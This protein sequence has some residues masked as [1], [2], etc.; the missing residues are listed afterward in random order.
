MAE[1]P[2]IE[3]LR[4]DL[5]REVAG[6]RVK[7]VEM[8]SLK[9]FKHHQNRKQVVGRLEG[10]KITGVRRRGVLLVFR[11][12]SGDALV[13]DVSRAGHLVRAAA[14]DEVA[15]G[16]QLIITFTQGGQL[17]VIDPTNGDVQMLITEF[18]AI[19]DVFPDLAAGG[20][21]PVEPINW[22]RFA[23]TLRGSSLKLKALL[24]D[25]S[26][27]L[28]IGPMYSDEIL[29]DSGL[30]GDRVANKLTTQEERR[31]Y[32]SIVEIMH[33]AIKHRGTSIGDDGFR[34]LSGAPGNYLEYI[35]AYERAGQACKRCRGTIGKRKIVGQQS[36]ACPDCQ[37]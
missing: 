7:T 25:P 15:T 22:V 8:T 30:R 1:L 17:R 20:L 34:D 33:D 3:T 27:L 6:K 29:W 35:N 24:M 28:G 10:T 36:F 4:H 26:I 37:V 14:K 5:E 21:D 2:E 16:T 9:S 18:D 13:V 19:D 31:L 32:R 11:L 12:D 23:E